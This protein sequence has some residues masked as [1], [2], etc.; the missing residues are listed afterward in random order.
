[1]GGSVPACYCDGVR[2]SEHAVAVHSE[3]NDKLRKNAQNPPL[4]CVAL[5]AAWHF[6]IVQHACSVLSKQLGSRNQFPIAH[7]QDVRTTIAR[8]CVAHTSTKAM[9]LTRGYCWRS[10]C[11]LMHD[12]PTQ[13]IAFI[14]TLLNRP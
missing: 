3:A 5:F 13:K 14:Y 10:A 8:G 1:M 4:Y 9:S 6:A 12:S 2:E 7:L 11:E